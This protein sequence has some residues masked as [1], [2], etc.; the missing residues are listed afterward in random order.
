MMKINSFLILVAITVLFAFIYACKKEP[1]AT[2][3]E[4]PVATVEYD[5]TPYSLQL[6]AFPAAPIAVDNQLTVQKILLGRMLFHEKALSRDG[7]MNCASCHIQ[8]FAFTDTARFSKGVLGL[9]GKRQGMAIFNMAWNNNEFFW[10]GRA[11]LLRDQALKPI[12]DTLE[13]HE[14]LENV[15]T[16]LKAK[17]NYKDQFKRAFGSEEINSERMSLALEQFMNTIVSTD[18]KYDRSLAN[19]AT[20]TISEENGRKLFF[21]EYNKFF[22]NSSGAE[23]AHCH[24]GFN[25]E[26]DDYMNNGLDTD[27]DLKDVGREKVTK[28]ASDRGKFKVPSLRNIAL[29]AP[30]MHDGRFKTLEE[31]VDHYNTGLKSSTHIDPALENTR[32]TGLMLDA[33]EKADLINFLKTLTDEKLTTNPKFSSPF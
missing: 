24:S 29:T 7:S 8:Q 18:S 30:Y 23:C 6:G 31:V 4:E 2:T 13:M 9:L 22:P 16:K 12:Q 5:E 1:I 19:T 10:D 14:S 28:N 26:N 33:T 15:V 20:L 3:A 21:G 11:H 25:F 27:A 17:Q 32:S